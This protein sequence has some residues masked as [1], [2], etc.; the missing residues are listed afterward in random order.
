EL[1]AQVLEPIVGIDAEAVPARVGEV[2]RY[3]EPVER[4]PLRGKELLEDPL[5]GPEERV[6][7]PAV[8]LKPRS[9][10]VEDPRPET[11]RRLELVEHDDD[12]LPGSFREG[13]R[14]IER[15]LEEPLRIGL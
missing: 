1:P 15:A 5:L 14:Q 3:R 2:E 4:V 8:G 12:T 7:R 10:H 11:S 13:L 6:A 9:H